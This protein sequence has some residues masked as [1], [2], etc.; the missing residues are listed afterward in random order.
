MFY[1]VKL[2]YRKFVLFI[3]TKMNLKLLKLVISQD[4]L[5]RFKI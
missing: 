5:T 2:Y 3:K 1:I 4:K